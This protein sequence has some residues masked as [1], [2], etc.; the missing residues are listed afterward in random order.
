MMCVKK[1]GKKMKL[2]QFS[3]HTS[4][5]ESDKVIFRKY[6]IDKAC[7]DKK[8][9]HFKNDFFIELH[10]SNSNGYN[11]DTG[12][13]YYHPNIL[14]PNL[15]F[16]KEYIVPSSTVLPPL[17]AS[18]SKNSINDSKL[19]TSP[20]SPSSPKTPDSGGKPFARENSGKNLKQSTKSDSPLINDKDGE[21]GDIDGAIF[22]DQDFA[23][24]TDEDDD[25]EEDEED[26]QDS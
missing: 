17:S 10:F 15:I 14:P 8:Q 22:S 3:F 16:D 2:A 18:I 6:E 13:V 25:E 23:Y 20:Q 1:Q 5:I 26:G 7:K 24:N 11:P 12:S 9:K 19:S 21:E 4:F